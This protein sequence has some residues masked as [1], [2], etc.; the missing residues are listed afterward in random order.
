MK[1]L[2]IEKDTELTSEEK[3]MFAYFGENAKI[4]PPY[5][6][7]NPHRIS[8]GDRTSIR[9]GAYIHAYQDLRKNMDYIDYKYKHE[10]N[11]EDYKYDSKIIIGKEVQINR[12][13]LMS[14]TNKIEL[15]N[16][17]GVGQGTFI[18]DNNH[19]FSHPNV[20]II[21]QPNEYGKPIYIGQ[22]TW[23]GLNTAILGATS[24]GINCVVGANSVVQGKYPNHAVISME[25]AKMI[26]QRYDLEEGDE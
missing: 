8:I 6:I 7:L 15:A 20:P 21:Q 14:C 5:R 9:E 18:G 13:I 17:V 22:G 12:F 23:I 19:M 16:N 11:E 2:L 1:D 26:F 4:R 24:L 10:F 3:K 25:K